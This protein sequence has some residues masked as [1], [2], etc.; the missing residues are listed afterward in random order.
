MQRQ[1]TMEKLKLLVDGKVFNRIVEALIIISLVTFPFETLP[2]LPIVLKDILYYIE[3]T[4][5]ILFTIEYILRLIVAEKSLKRIFSASGI[6][7]L[8]AFFP[9]YVIGADFRGIRIFRLFRMFRL[10][11]SKVYSETLDKFKRA[12]HYSKFELLLFFLISLAL[13]YVSSV[14]IY[15][16]EHTAQPDNFTSMFD[17]IWWS[18]VTLTTTGYGDMYP[19]TVA[20]KVFTA[21]MLIIGVGIIIIPASLFAQAFHKVNNG[22][23]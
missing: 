15:Y 16:F 11:G 12:F 19:I 17:G 22:K 13:L 4:I 7:D 14:I 6:V 5:I 8:L 9:F 23:L 20:G 21:F 18:I 2:N 10:F 3:F 1:I